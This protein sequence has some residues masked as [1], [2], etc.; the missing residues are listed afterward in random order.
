MD[1]SAVL[2]LLL[3]LLHAVLCVSAAEI[4]KVKPQVRRSQRVR[5]QLHQNKR[6][7]NQI[8]AKYGYHRRGQKKWSP[9]LPPPKERNALWGKPGKR[10]QHPINDLKTLKAPVKRKT[11][12]PPLPPKKERSGIWA[13]ER[14][15]GKAPRPVGR[16]RKA[17]H[18][19]LERR[20][21]KQLRLH[22]KRGPTITYR[23]YRRDLAENF[24]YLVG[25]IIYTLSSNSSLVLRP[26][27]LDFP[28]TK[29]QANSSSIL[30]FGC[31]PPQV[32]QKGGAHRLFL[33]T[34]TMQGCLEPLLACPNP[35]LIPSLYTSIKS[36]HFNTRNTV[37]DWNVWEDKSNVVG[38]YGEIMDMS[39]NDF[40]DIPSIRY[41]G[42]RWVLVRS[43]TRKVWR[44]SPH[45]KRLLHHANHRLGSSAVV[46]VHVTPLRSSPSK[47]AGIGSPPGVFSPTLK[48]KKE[49]PFAI[50]LMAMER[51]WKEYQERQKKVGGAKKTKIAFVY[52]SNAEEEKGFKKQAKENGGWDII[53][54]RDA[55]SPSTSRDKLHAKTIFEV[56]SA[57]I[58]SEL[59]YFVGAAS[60]GLSWTIQALRKQPLKTG[61]SLDDPWSQRI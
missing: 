17:L 53:T 45:M 22:C 23:T 50:Y 1:F 60:S 51:V 44:L 40:L 19:D 38:I 61:I 54:I 59:P 25:A 49:S 47:L 32:K 41:K 46:G 5:N 48:T 21:G 24:R 15:T 20:I 30:E 35:A 43:I 31:F 13:A 10:S 33:L 58:M 2:G 8:Y 27:I 11:W 4:E 56:L 28:D 39:V 9:P 34:N 36:H 29:R 14:H 16:R 3:A 57:N 12:I 18:S 55:M 37:I 6:V 7:Q 42:A 26:P 52:A